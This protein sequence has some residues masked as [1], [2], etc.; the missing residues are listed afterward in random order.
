MTSNYIPANYPYTNEISQAYSDGFSAGY[1]DAA[2]FHTTNSVT[3]TDNIGNQRAYAEGYIDSRDYH[4][5]NITSGTDLTGVLRGYAEGYSA[6]Y[7]AGYNTGYSN[8]KVDAPRWALRTPSNQ[9][10][11]NNSYV[12]VNFNSTSATVRGCTH[13]TS[14]DRIYITEAGT[15]ELAC[16]WEMTL[17]GNSAFGAIMR[18]SL[19]RNGSALRHGDSSIWS[20]STPYCMV[21]AREEVYLNVGD[22]IE[23]RAYTNTNGTTVVKQVSAD[24]TDAFFVGFKQ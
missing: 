13:N 14:L 2:N 21:T 12:R 8:G 24:A 19:F 16:G 6:G 11:A 9:T 23:C 5:S 7:S 20:A 4:T 10:I 22:Y 1:L 18:A 15:Y 17:S 3:G